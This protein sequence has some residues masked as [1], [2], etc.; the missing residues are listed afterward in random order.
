MLTQK[1]IASP[2]TNAE[3]KLQ[4]YNNVKTEIET[5]SVVTYIYNRTSIE[6][7]I[8]IRLYISKEQSQ[9]HIL[10]PILS[11]NIVKY[12]LAKQLEDSSTLFFPNL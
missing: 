1:K 8:K 12:I 5:I 2:E 4:N 9:I 11:K 3:T 10:K 6:K 7:Q